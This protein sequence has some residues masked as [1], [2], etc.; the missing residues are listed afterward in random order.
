MLMFGILF[1]FSNYIYLIFV[2]RFLFSVDIEYSLLSP[3]VVK[4][5]SELIK[6]YDFRSQY[7]L[8]M[9]NR[10]QNSKIDKIGL[11]LSKISKIK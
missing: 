2:F 4:I 6:S 5:V 3:K 11:K 8:N 10:F 7:I 9:Q 1:Y